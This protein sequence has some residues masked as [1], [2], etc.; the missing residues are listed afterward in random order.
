MTEKNWTPKLYILTKV[1]NP[2]F[3]PPKDPDEYVR[4]SKKCFGVHPDNLFVSDP[5]DGP[6]KI[7]P[8]PSTHYRDPCGKVRPRK[9]LSIKKFQNGEIEYEEDYYESD[10]SE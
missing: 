4:F 3:G 1:Y 8:I 6:E 5:I 7:I 10:E 9:C 2:L